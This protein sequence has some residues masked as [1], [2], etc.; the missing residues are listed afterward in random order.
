MN[1][2]K[3]SPFVMLIACNIL[4]LSIIFSSSVTAEEQQYFVGIEPQF[5]REDWYE[6]D[7]LNSNILPF[8]YEK[9]VIEHVGL[10]LRSHVYLHTG[11]IE[12]TAISLVGVGGA[13]LWYLDPQ[14]QFD[15]QGFNLGPAAI[16]SY[17]FLENINHT[18]LAVETGYTFAIS[19]IWSTNVAIQ[20]GRSSLSGNKHPASAHFGLFINIGR[21]F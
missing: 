8:V 12:G 15:M 18:T 13:L 17:D 11:G 4:L 2:P 20:Y 16:Y 10:R 14:D 9:Q 5:N 19:N 1:C 21:W 3:F 7:E 6:D